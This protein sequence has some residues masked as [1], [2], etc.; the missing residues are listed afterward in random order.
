MKVEAVLKNL[1]TGIILSLIYTGLYGQTPAWIDFDKQYYRL[2]TAQDAIYRITY[3]D[4]NQIGFPLSAVGSEEYQ[5]FFRGEE[6]AIR[7]IDG[8]DGQLNPGDYLEF[9]GARN[10]G[11]LDAELYL[12]P[13]AQPHQFQNLYSD[14]TTF[15]LTW[16]TAGGKRMPEI[17]PQNG[18]GAR[19]YHWE[20]HLTIQDAEYSA[21]RRYPVGGNGETFLSQFD[22]G[23]GF[24]G[25]RIANG[26]FEEF[27][28]QV[29]QPHRPG[30]SPQLQVLLAGRNETTHQVEILV[31]SSSGFRSLGSLEF[32]NFDNGLFT[33]DLAWADIPADGSLQVRVSVTNTTNDRVS[34]SYLSLRYPQQPDMSGVSSKI[35]DFQS[36]GSVENQ[37]VITNPPPGVMVY[38][39]TDR[40][41]LAI[42][43]HEISPTSIS[44]NLPDITSASKILVAKDD[45]P[46][47]ALVE[48]ALFRQIDPSQH[49]YIIISHRLLRAPSGNYQDPVQAYAEYRASASGG[50]FDTL[51]VDMQMLYDQYHYGEISPL[52]IR[53]FLRDMMAGNPQYLLL[54]G[55]GFNVNFKPYRQDLSAATTRDLVPTAGFPGSDAAFSAGLG[56]SG[57][58]AAIATGRINAR[59]PQDVAAYLDKIKEA[60]SQE[61]DVLWRKRA[62]H[63]SGGLTQGELVLFRNFVDQFK[64]VAEGPYVGGDVTTIN[65]Q[66][67]ETTVLINVADE[68]N[69]GVN[70]ITFFGHSSTTTTDIEIGK[71]TNASL[72][73]D[74]PGRYPM[75]MVNGCNAGNVFFTSVGFGE[76]WILAPNKGALGFLAHTDA[77]FASNLK[78]YSDFYYQV[79]FGDSA[80]VNQPIGKILQELGSRYL[81]SVPLTEIHIAQVQQEVF[82]GD[83][84][85]RFFSAEKPDFQTDDQS[86]SLEPF[87]G[88]NLNAQADSFR[89]SIIARNLGRT[90]TDSLNVTVR[91]T[92]SDGQMITYDSVFYPPLLFQDT[93]WF[94]V[95]SNTISN[96]GNNQFE[97]L[98]DFNQSVD[99]LDESNNTGTLSFF[100]PQGGTVNAWP[101]AYSI[102]DSV[103]V[104]LTV[105]ASDL[106]SG[107]RNFSLQIDTTKAFN[108]PWKQQNT[109]RGHGLAAWRVPLLADS[110]PNDS[111]VYYW[112]SRFQTP[113]A[114]EDTAWVVSSFIRIP[115]SPPGWSQAQFPQFDEGAITSGITRNQSAR[116]WDFTSTETQVDITTYG[117]DHEAGE[118][119]NIQVL[120][121][122]QPFIVST[123]LCPDNSINAIAF[124]RSTTIPYAVLTTGGFDVLDPK[125][126]GRT[127]QVI[128]TFTNGDMQDGSRMLEYLDQLPAGDRVILFTIGEVAYENWNP[129]IIDQWAQIGVNANDL[130]NLAAGE[131]LIIK[132]RKGDQEGEAE[133]FRADPSSSIPLGA[134]ELSISEL[135]TGQANQ[136][137]I[138][139]TKIGPAASWETLHT[140]IDAF[141][142]DQVLYQ[143]LGVDENARETVVFNNV[144]ESALDLSRVDPRTYPFLRLRL[145]VTDEVELTPPQLK[146][147]QVIYTPV[148]EGV[149]LFRGN[150]P[151]QTSE[152]P[153][154][155][156]QLLETDFTF[157]NVSHYD[158]ADSLLVRA[159][160]FNRSARETETSEFNL[161]AL[162]AGDS[163]SFTTTIQT[164]EKSGINDYRVFVNPNLLPEQQYNNNIN[165]FQ[166]YLKVNTDDTHP[167]LDVTFDGIY[168]LDGDIVS[169]TPLITIRLKEDNPFNLKQD[170]LGVEM[171]IKRN[172]PGCNN[173]AF[174]RINFSDPAINWSPA[175]ESSD[176]RVEYQ[177]DAFSDGIYTLQV[178]AEDNTGRKSG[179]EPYTI[180]FEVITESTI[181]NFYPYPNPFSTSTRFVFTLT[182]ADIPQELKIQIMTVTGKVVREITQDEL[183]PLS[184]G[185][186]I[187]EYAWD[188]RDEY[189]DQ[190]A[191]GVYLY[192]VVM[193]RGPDQFSHRQTSADKAFKKGYGKLYLLR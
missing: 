30:P 164:Q 179:A 78:R 14:T 85:Y 119:G 122:G 139:S 141:S 167:I 168:L 100:I 176:F 35:F 46:L 24:T 151:D 133:V 63:L 124:D 180:N 111:I 23:E 170:T 101:Y 54:L 99:E 183:G 58:N 165:D 12:T 105:H 152:I 191:N 161:K 109:L 62:I 11:I 86:I 153:L 66:T 22:F 114:G 93:L 34:V 159:S 49:N 118:P 96:F 172:D 6:Q 150:E 88:Q 166:Q 17:S 117:P 19:S 31:G 48:K 132:G 43:S 154:I 20:Q 102:M 134:Q 52:A 108:S 36:M 21:G 156:G 47:S 91:R 98:L 29:T 128:N 87:E 137:S 83:P 158:F 71:V 10:D 95:R 192:R 82:Q 140:Q 135:I 40:N 189:G 155:E 18:A 72:G 107:E 13:E 169:P 130:S 145:L 67:N 175:T 32:E 5:I 45:Q 171:F 27:E 42:I 84:A 193:N 185:N 136:G 121:G 7:I 120:I 174:A 190:L 81:Q 125:R 92:F 90:T 26:S 143:V 15:F 157:F 97:V 188:G 178:Q 77:G 115:G 104:D 184:V 4:L 8:N 41:N 103:Q 53:K 182:G 89:V 112:R 147:W 131:P 138:T 76:D 44:F 61:A 146:K 149:L 51:L 55:K 37:V 74:N 9:Y 70:L 181:T 79:A 177:P 57:F 68:V 69:Q 50:G 163:V 144:T 187:S 65:K 116:R 160:L 127:P 3:D 60:E 39:I 33:S 64:G 162:Q 110:P 126:C 16:G 142:S 94:T 73:Y 1:L 129:L 148:P 59:T 38:H 173:C 113:Q 186:N 2:K 80:F 123:R 28:V 56:N 75:I 106:T 25:R